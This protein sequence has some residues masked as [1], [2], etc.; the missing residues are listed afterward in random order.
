LMNIFPFG[1]LPTPYEFKDKY[2]INTNE[3]KFQATLDCC[4]R[5]PESEAFNEYMKLPDNLE[6]EIG[7]EEVFRRAVMDI[8]IERYTLLEDAY[9]TFTM[10][11]INNES[12]PDSRGGTFIR[13][14]GGASFFFVNKEGKIEIQPNKLEE[15]IAGVEAARI[16]RCEACRRVFWAG[17]TTQKG[18]SARCGDIIRKRRYRERYRQGLYQG[19]KLTEKEKAALKLERK[20]HKA[21]RGK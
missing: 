14:M 21:K 5:L 13:M 1:I 9:L 11:I 4:A 17:R 7:D 2:D 19:A 10:I 16:R 8:T 3:G 18:C 15:A 12:S 6:Q 20:Q